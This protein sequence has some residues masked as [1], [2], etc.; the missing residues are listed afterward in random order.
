ML[1]EKKKISHRKGATSFV[2]SFRIG[3][4]TGHRGLWAQADCWKAGG[5]V[6]P[7]GMLLNGRQDNGVASQPSVKKV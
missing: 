5:S 4:G 2:T 6:H 7:A 3:Q 1:E